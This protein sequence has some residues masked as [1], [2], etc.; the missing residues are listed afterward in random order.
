MFIRGGW[1]QSFS[2]LTIK[3]VFFVFFTY[4]KFRSI[5]FTKSELIRTG[6]HNFFTYF[7]YEANEVFIRFPLPSLQF[8]SGPCVTETFSVVKTRRFRRSLKNISHHVNF[9]ELLLQIAEHK[10][11]SIAMAILPYSTYLLN[12]YM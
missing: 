5:F 11:V 3:K 9:T 10:T 12:R 2:A 7:H 6:L 4:F 8:C 1:P